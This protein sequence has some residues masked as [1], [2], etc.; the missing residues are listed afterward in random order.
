[1]AYTATSTPYWRRW[2]E[3]AC[4]GQLA[5]LSLQL[6]NGEEKTEE[7][8]AK[9]RQE[10]RQKGQAAHSNEI[11]GA[12]ILLSGFAALKYGGAFMYQD[13]TAYMRTMLS[14]LNRADLTVAAVSV[15]AGDFI[16]L[17]LKLMA[18]VALSVLVA[19]LVCSFLQ[20]GPMFTMT[21]LAPSWEKINPLSGWQRLFSR[22]SLVELVKSVVKVAVVSVFIYRFIILEAG[23]IPGLIDADL[24]GALAMTGAL[25]TQLIWQIGGVLLILAMGD[26]FFQWWDFK[27]SLKMSRQ[28]IKEEMKQTEGN[29]QLKGRLR[30]RQ[31][32]LARRRMMQEVP[33]ADV[34]VTNPTHY[35]VAL[36]YQP[37]YPAPLVVA[38]G[39]GLVAAR[40]K[41]IAQAH[42]VAIVENQPLARALYAAVEVGE[43]IPEELYQAVAEVLAYVYR[44][45]RKLS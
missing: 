32:A 28:E 31:R 9:R 16:T 18:P 34:V 37:G 3:S 20:V 41:E 14:E 40:I 35:A 15:L 38:K 1:M 27:Q 4:E 39:Q 22:R 26:Y 45:Q 13:M 12:I 24:A 42:R 7:P 30:E 19:G 25:T 33:T 44:L 11:N 2:P 6:F 5:T 21:P 23:Q 8:T 10:A 43:A 36:K 29:P 17:F